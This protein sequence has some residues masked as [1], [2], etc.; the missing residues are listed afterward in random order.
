MKIFRS[1]KAYYG[2]LTIKER[3]LKVRIKFTIPGNPFGKQRPYV[4]NKRGIKR[5]ETVLHENIAREAWHNAYSGK[6]FEWDIALDII[7]YYQIPKGWPK[8]KQQAAR[9]GYIRPN[10][11]GPSKPDVDNVSKLIMDSLNPTKIGK[12]T[13]P[14]T[15]IYKD[16]GQVV[17][18]AIDSYYSD[19]PRAEVTVTAYK[20][21]DLAQIKEK[22]KK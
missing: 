6:T 15:G 4:V 2:V 5:K 16:D 9:L 3:R 14:N 10:K 22:V 13:V 12:K 8:W 21:P 1:S 20:K 17:H 19:D 18:L 11:K 7:A